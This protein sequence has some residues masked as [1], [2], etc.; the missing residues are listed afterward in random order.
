M[1]TFLETMQ[2]VFSPAEDHETSEKLLDL[3][4]EL[5]EEYVQ[6]LEKEKSDLF[7][8]VG[9]DIVID[10]LVDEKGIGDVFNDT[11]IGKAMESLSSLSSDFK[12]FREKL[13]N[14]TTEEDLASLKNTII[15]N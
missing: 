12:N 10:Y 15:T 5:A 2:E 14:A 7:L 4:K 11:L 13:N 1:T 9:R 8:S 3:K 6:R